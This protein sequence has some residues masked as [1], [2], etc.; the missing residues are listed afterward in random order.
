MSKNSF[1][2]SQNMILKD[3]DNMNHRVFY[4]SEKYCVLCNMDSN[5]MILKQISTKRLDELCCTG[6]M[7]PSTETIKVY[8]FEKFSEHAKKEHQKNLDF[9]YDVE[10]LFDNDFLDLYHREKPDQIN[11]LMEKHS[12]SRKTF[13]KKILSYLKSG[14][15][16]YSLLDG[17]CFPH[18]TVKYNYKKKPG[19]PSEFINGGIIVTDKVKGHFDYAINLYKRVRNFTYPDVYN[20]MIENYYS[21]NGNQLAETERP[22]FEQFYYYAKKQ[23]DK[24]TMEEIKTSKREYRNDKRKLDGKSSTGVLYPGQLV[25]MDAQEINVS[26]VSSINNKACVSRPT[27]YAI[28]DVKTHL[29]IAVSLSFEQNSNLGFRNCMINLAEDKMTYCKRYNVDLINTKRWP[30]N[31]YP[32]SMRFDRGPEFIS[33]DT[34]RILREMNIKYDTVPGATGSLKGVVENTFNVL[35]QK[36][37]GI[38]ENAGYIQDRYDSK[39]HEKSCLTIEEVTTIFINE[40]IAHNHKVM[41][42]FEMTKDMILN[43]VSPSPINLWKYG[44][45]KKAPRPITNLDQYAYTVMTK[46]TGVKLSRKGIMYKELYY[47][48]PSDVELDDEIYELGSKTRTFECRMDVCD[49]SKLY[50][51]KHNTLQVATLNPAKVEDYECYERMSLD[52]YHE[53]IKQSKQIKAE[54]KQKNTELRI[55]TLRENEAIVKNALKRKNGKSDTKHIKENRKLEKE[56]FRSENTIASHLDLSTNNESIEDKPVLNETIDKTIT[57]QTMNYDDSESYMEEFYE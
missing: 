6:E 45:T 51:I 19:R 44:C 22:T 54:A 47:H 26:L 49:V 50:Y 57:I 18:K 53:L 56:R 46:L 12:M 32:R 14:C 35:Q 1:T 11:E 55:N 36:Y 8:D 5:H 20:K 48:N 3:N 27:A 39:H 41:E 25:E 24:K 17:R 7:V 37:A 34:R 16:P 15:N 43:K 2:I 42:D 52:K 9:I 4:V 10:N 13:R 40:V 29:I 28:V 33:K 38:L 21:S 23:I 30:S 31:I